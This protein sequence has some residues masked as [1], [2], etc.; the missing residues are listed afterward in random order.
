MNAGN[1][2]HMRMGQQ[3]RALRLERGLQQS[4]MAR[5]LDISAAYLSLIEKGRRSVQLPLLFKALEIYGI[6]MEAFMESLG[7][8][9]VDDGLEE[10]LADPLV[11]SLH[12]TEE[13]IAS[14]SSEP[15]MVTTITALFNLYKSTRRQ[16]DSVLEGIAQREKSS[17]PPVA[18]IEPQ[19]SV[20]RFELSPFD[21]VTEFLESRENWFPDLERRADS[22]RSQLSLPPRYT[23]EAL[24]KAM[25]DTFDIDVRVIRTG[26]GDSSVVRRWDPSAGILTLSAELPEQRVRFQLAHTIGLRLLHQEDVVDSI[27]RDTRFRFDETRSLVA[28]H[29]ANYFAGALLL[30]YDDFF[31]EVQKSRY[32]I[33][34]LASVFDSSYETVAHRVCNLS[35]PSRRGLP[36]YFLRVDIAGN[37]SKRY[38]AVGLRFGHNMGSCPKSAAHLAFLTPP[39]IRRRYERYP[40]GT[41]Y[42][43][44]AKVVSE[45]KAGS[46]GRGTTY[47]IALGTYADNAQHLAYA[48]DMP[49]A[50][51]E[52][53]ALP[54]GVS[55]RFCER[56]DCNQRAAP[57]Y[58][59]AFRVDAHTKK[60][61]FFSPLV[62]SDEEAD[63]SVAAKKPRGT[64]RRTC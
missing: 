40:D 49:F 6:T 22:V 30:P 48:D 19:G 17:T 15:R 28:I 56:T 42:F 35:D 53:M 64:S 41:T 51:P 8:R 3:L 21:E 34:L 5:R 46:L 47:S 57:S 7:D 23:S 2:Q 52:R 9:R 63:V 14:I 24:I 44:F 13:D 45:P 54:V 55:C 27:T 4:E 25:R 37:I 43:V 31:H 32:D 60:D 10:L 16:L 39:I 11:R 58:K 59:F 62:Q 38:S 20:L 50:D 29:L 36:F 1:D 26:D 18:P 61:N 33:E 12:L